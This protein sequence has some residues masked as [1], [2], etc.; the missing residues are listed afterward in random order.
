[1]KQ[2]PGLGLIGLVRAMFGHLLG[3]V[4]GAKNWDG[5][6]L[7]RDF[8]LNYVRKFHLCCKALTGATF[9][10]P[11]HLPW[12]LRHLDCQIMFSKSF[13]PIPLFHVANNVTFQR[14]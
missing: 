11:V 6:R 5:A 2:C 8:T 1:M 14:D 9:D 7:R 12:F 10:A 3:A 13:V 4:C